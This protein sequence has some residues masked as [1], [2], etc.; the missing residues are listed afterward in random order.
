M[1]PTLIG[2]TSPAV[3]ATMISSSRASPSAVFP[4]AM[5]A[6]PLPSLARAMA[7]GSPNRSAISVSRLNRS[8]ADAASPAI[9]LRSASGT[10]R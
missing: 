10:S 2:E 3:I 5:R 7:S 8:Y 4:S 9:R 1:M 6:W